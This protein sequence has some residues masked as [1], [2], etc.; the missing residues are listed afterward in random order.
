MAENDVNINDGYT[1]TGSG[2][3]KAASDLLKAEKARRVAEG[4]KE[5]NTLLNPSDIGGGY[6]PSRALETTLGGVKRALTPE[7]LD[8]FSRIVDKMK[9]GA[10][11]NK[12][13]GGIRPQQVIA[14]SQKIDIERSNK[15]IHF[16]ALLGGSKG[17]LRF[18]TNASGETPGVNRHF[19]NVTL[20][21]FDTYSAMPV[22]PKK[23]TALGKACSNDRVK[24]ECDCGRFTFWYRYLATTGGWVAGRPET[25]Y[26]KIRNP[27]LTG[28]ACK[29]ILRV[30]RELTT[31]THIHRQVAKMLDKAIEGKALRIKQEDIDKQLRQQ[32]KNRKDIDQSKAEKAAA[33][34]LKEKVAR[35]AR[36]K[37]IESE[38]T[39]GRVETV[40]K[41]LA[42]NRLLLERGAIDKETYKEL[43]ELAMDTVKSLRE[44]KEI[45]PATYKSIM[46]LVVPD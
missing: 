22:D 30:M 3:S 36:A 2:S 33:K 35:V 18:Q 31:S 7:D 23:T 45:L 4:R 34:L 37:I 12:I 1:I 24:I 20:A 40:K 39:I 11:K 15:Q 8:N 16:A 6:D 17:N 42:R 28:V 10:A 38:A 27:E 44:Q 43:T 5:K 21:A 25:A 13:K 29:H 14:L 32:K 9:A 46:S 19:V 26:P 41:N